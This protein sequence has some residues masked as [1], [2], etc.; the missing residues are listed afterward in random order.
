VCCL[1]SRAAAVSIVLRRRKL[2]T[3]LQKENA[4]ADTV[5]CR[6]RAGPMTAGDLAY[7]D[8]KDSSAGA[9]KWS[10]RL[11]S[12]PRP[13]TVHV[14]VLIGYLAAG[15]A[16][17]WT[18]AAYLTG[19]VV[20]GDARDTGLFVWDFWWMAHSVAH[21]SNP[22]FT[23]YLAAPVGTPLA[24]HVLMPLPGVL[25]TPVTLVYGPSF[26]YN[27][28]GCGCPRRSAR[29]PRVRSLACPR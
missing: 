8:R 19:H 25:M 5:Q 24:F 7:G 15:I 17:N 13:V 11:G 3:C 20:P 16:V 23:H 4:L 6:S 10:W 2:L 22:W 14:A 27:L 18:R 21:L 1:R 9:G 29:L 28:P 26:T 12:V